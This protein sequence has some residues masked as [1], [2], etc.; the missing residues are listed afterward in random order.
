MDGGNAGFKRS[1]ELPHDF[2]KRLQPVL[3]MLTEALVEAQPVNIESF[4]AFILETAASQRSRNV[5]ISS[6]SSSPPPNT[7]SASPSSAA[8]VADRGGGGG[9]AD[10]DGEEDDVFSVYLEAHDVLSM[11]PGSPEADAILRQIFELFDEDGDGVLSQPEFYA[12]LAGASLNMSEQEINREMLSLDPTLE[13]Y[14]T[15]EA[16]VP[17]CLEL[18]CVVF[19]RAAALEAHEEALSAAIQIASTTIKEYSKAELGSIMSSAFREFAQSDARALTFDEFEALVRSEKLGLAN[20][21]IAALYAKASPRG[22]DAA[23]ISYDEFV[24]VY[25]EVMYLNQ[26]RELLREDAIAHM[27]ERSD[28]GE[29]TAHLQNVFQSFDETLCGR[30]APA[31]LREILE[32]SGL[33]LSRVL[34]CAM[35][36]MAAVDSDG[37][38]DYSLYV[39]TGAQLLTYYKRCK[40]LQRQTSVR[41]MKRL[42]S[43]AF[44]P[45][46]VE[47]V[48]GVNPEQY[49]QLLRSTFKRLDGDSDGFVNALELRSHFEEEG[50]PSDE[51]TVNAVMRSFG[52][53][54]KHE[55]N[56]C[57]FRRVMYDILVEL[58]SSS[59]STSAADGQAHGEPTDAASGVAAAAA[60]AA[61]AA[62]DGVQMTDG[63]ESAVVRRQRA[64]VE[65][66]GRVRA[67]F[68]K[69][70]V[71]DVGI[72]DFANVSRLLR[73]LQVVAELDAGTKM[74][75]LALLSF[76]SD[77][78][79][80]RMM[81]FDNYV[82]CLL[83][84]E[85]AEQ[86][87]FPLDQL[88]DELV[89]A[90]GQ[91]QRQL[92]SPSDSQKQ[93]QHGRRVAFA[94][95]TTRASVASNANDGDGD[96]EQQQSGRVTAS[97]EL[98]FVKT[99]EEV[100][101]DEEMVQTVMKMSVAEFVAELK[102]AFHAADT[103]KDGMLNFAELVAYFESQKMPIGI[104]GSRALLSLY[105]NSSGRLDFTAF[106]RVMYDVIL[107]FEY[108]HR[109]VTAVVESNKDSATTPAKEA[110]SKSVVLA[111][112]DTRLDELFRAWDADNKGFVD[113]HDLAIALNKLEAMQSDPSAAVRFT[114]H[115]LL[116][117]DHSGKQR[118]DREA[119][120]ELIVELCISKYGV[121][122]EVLADHLLAVSSAAAAAGH[123]GT[124]SKSSR[125]RRYRSG[126][127]PATLTRSR[128][129]SVA[130]D[131]AKVEQHIGVSV[132]EFVHEL[133][134]SFDDAD[135]NR[136]GFLD[137]D[138]LLACM[139]AQKVLLNPDSISALISLFDVG[140]RRI[141]FRGF[142]N[143][144]YDI[145][146]EYAAYAV[147]AEDDM[148][149]A[150]KVEAKLNR[151][152]SVKVASKDARMRELFDAWDRS[153]NG[154][155]A[156]AD[157]A[158]ALRG[159]DQL[160][161]ANSSVRLA[162]YA[163]LAHD[164]TASHSLD[165]AAFA[166]LI[167]EICEERY[168]LEFGALADQLLECARRQDEEFAADELATRSGG[169][170]AAASGG[171]THARDKSLRVARARSRRPGA[172]GGAGAAGGA[173]IGGG[174]V[175]SSGM[176]D[177]PAF[178][179]ANTSAYMDRERLERMLGVSAEEFTAELKEAFVAADTNNDGLLDYDDLEAYFG[180]NKF[181]LSP[182]A[183]R[184]L[185]AAFNASGDPSLPCIDYRGFKKI[186]YDMSVE[187]C[188]QPHELSAES[189][190]RSRRIRKI[191][192]D[193]RL[194]E[195]FAAWDVNGNGAVNFRDV[196]AALHRFEGV[197]DAQNDVRLTIYAILA[198][199]TNDG[200][201]RNSRN[202]G[203][204]D[205]FATMLADLCQD[206]YHLEFDDIAPFLLEQ[207]RASKASISSS[208][209]SPPPNAPC[210]SP[211]PPSAMSGG[212]WNTST[213]GSSTRQVSS[214]S[215][216]PASPD[217]MVVPSSREI[218]RADSAA[219]RAMMFTRAASTVNMDAALVER[220]LGIS[221]AE[222]KEELKQ[223]FIEADED[224]DGYLTLGEF[225]R[226]VEKQKLPI[227]RDGV[228]A[229]VELFDVG[230]ERVDF[231][232]FRQILYGIT[233]EFARVEEKQQAKRT[234]AEERAHAVATAAAKS[235][236][237]MK[238]LFDAW[239]FDSKGFVNFRDLACEM[240]QLE[241][242]RD[243]DAAVRL[244]VFALLSFDKK[245]AQ[246]LAFE[247]F[248]ELIVQLCDDQY[249]IEFEF[250][251][252]RLLVAASKRAQAATSASTTRGMSSRVM[253]SSTSTPGATVR[254]ALPEAKEKST[255]VAADA[256][257]GGDGG[258]M[259]ARAHTSRYGARTV[260]AR[261]NT[262][263]KMDQS[264][265]ENV[266]GVSVDEFVGELKESFVDADR[267]KD[268]YLDV[269][270]LRAYMQK[271]KMPID[272][273]G[274]KALVKLFDV[275]TKAIGVAAIDFRG[276]KQICY[277][278]LV[279]FAN[280]ELEHGVNLREL[281]HDDPL[282]AHAKQDPRMKALF[283]RWDTG[284]KG[285]VDFAD[286]VEALQSM[287]GMAADADSAVRTSV[288]AL[289]SFDEEG[290]LALTYTEFVLF[291]LDLADDLLD[292][293]FDEVVESLLEAAAKCAS[294]PRA[295]ENGHEH[296][297]PRDEKVPP[298]V[299]SRTMRGVDV[300][301]VEQLLGIPV[302]QFNQEL[303]ESFMQA[304]KDG[305]GYL[306]YSDLA[307]YMKA[308]SADMDDNE[309]SEIVSKFASAAV[310]ITGGAN[311]AVGSSNVGS[312]SDNTEG[313]SESR[314]EAKI[315]FRAFRR[316][317]FD[318]LCNHVSAATA[319][320]STAAA[321]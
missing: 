28:A 212:G 283:K 216:A 240:R 297:T 157:L 30:F 4:A 52:V 45:R 312:G 194:P 60:T 238:A 50:L 300:R 317:S 294:P 39:T 285:Y 277:D 181:E 151:A 200:L 62:G 144:C 92:P 223:S 59:N 188:A 91:Q 96:G 320:M 256:S 286:I 190:E 82:D 95:T 68:Q 40:A 305:D 34:L 110:R 177:V 243:A 88:L 117:F 65:R 152:L 259:G 209:C 51:S 241:P 70:D 49:E 315:D 20:E 267:N 159:M 316:I 176:G 142:K 44:E 321:T 171:G 5:S 261:S 189:I 268:G 71:D 173:R 100:V 136:D 221:V 192:M 202:S 293:D 47:R 182:A 291:V 278:M 220:M 307:S 140:G 135:K 166:E 137:F 104:S 191:K 131:A 233:I 43:V 226:Y 301:K 179:R 273:K 185:I 125:S 90:L 105:D 213:G 63:T 48:L 295:S 143:I 170:D 319:H 210:A 318:V 274:T 146:V 193:P 11:E 271:Q 266:L 86:F 23:F 242:V 231:R 160:Q 234:E 230:G 308:L 41:V 26:V 158:L 265:V 253:S 9:V 239:D 106:K 269:G 74:G 184:A 127:D 224:K 32:T 313:G 237:R 249:G 215:F 99:E 304:D 77:L 208:S 126:A 148:E 89:A 270:E 25:A 203:D 204:F 129:E 145:L 76:D 69:F 154:S 264:K 236:P 180:R 227:D 87:E 284:R 186:M 13:G 130:M 54:K 229:L 225:R 163:L 165:F 36:G 246:R 107:I 80:E 306:E 35:A 196:S 282:I 12:A 108:E 61:A 251:A 247:E 132:E 276:F 178:T 250:V 133:R 310:P 27:L 57:G 38:I 260:F 15:F 162:V 118:V 33:G 101:M 244:T 149:L 10:A 164:Q 183:I 24:P 7:S 73:R 81:S 292:A 122:F 228:R 258:G 31:Q 64:D 298:M 195:L 42:V 120:A 187:F 214:V 139:Q 141:D 150:S 197:A 8:A 46:V 22:L 138:E 78:P 199:E 116:S 3:Q 14:V 172:G 314:N 111:K 288:H 155:I 296:E 109:A 205:T 245:G 124:R 83:S 290:N 255:A 114:L 235:D 1:D 206:R 161:D 18:I 169:D 84:L 280:R 254:F 123:V 272:A 67:T 56:L 29:F 21:E 299:R 303:K 113:F 94:S 55:I 103:D 93:K 147:D 248:V 121:E 219:S 128:Q 222:Y 262:T 98:A 19:A 16:F 119:F 279:E 309:V 201:R 134:E 115:A 263:V 275:G 156:F 302:E 232:G 174:G 311:G 53:G 2:M 287:G 75:V 257:G 97:A 112:K 207:A 17:C 102:G 58:D 6:S 211:A 79:E 167:V 281:V 72:V 198:V 168:G 153:G 217:V 218:S 252:E 289:V 66:D 85:N 175:S 37:T